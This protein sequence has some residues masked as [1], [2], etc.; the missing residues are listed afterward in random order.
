MRILGIDPGLRVTGFGVIDQTGHHQLTY[1]ASG[2]IKTQDTDLPTRLGTIFDGISM[3]IRRR[4]IR[5]SSTSIR[6]RHCCLARHA[7][8]QFAGW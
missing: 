7:A 8:P 2:V 6:S 1:V 3:L 5:C 4:S